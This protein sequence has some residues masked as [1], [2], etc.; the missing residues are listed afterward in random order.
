MFVTKHKGYHVHCMVIGKDTN[1]TNA[2]T[3]WRKVLMILTIPVTVVCYA[4]AI[5]VCC[6]HPKRSSCW[7]RSI[8]PPLW[9]M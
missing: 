5:G 3:T 6:A 9:H 4:F 2:G 1:V 7:T 8:I